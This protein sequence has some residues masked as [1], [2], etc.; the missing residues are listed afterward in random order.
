MLSG[1]IPTEF[2]TSTTFSLKG[3]YIRYTP[4][5]IYK[6]ILT[7]ITHRHSLTSTFLIQLRKHDYS[8]IT[9]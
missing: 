1:I 7:G 2:L 3:Y 5:N 9:N 6:K 8:I 4:V